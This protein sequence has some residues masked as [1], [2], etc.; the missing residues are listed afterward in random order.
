MCNLP[1]FWLSLNFRFSQQSTI[2]IIKNRA[3][4]VER[5]KQLDFHSSKKRANTMS[6]RF[7]MWAKKKTTESKLNVLMSCCLQLHDCNLRVA[8]ISHRHRRRRLR[9]TDWEQKNKRVMKGFSLSTQ[10]KYYINVRST[11][12]QYKKCFSSYFISLQFDNVE[13]CLEILRQNQVGGLE[14][15]TANDICS[16]R[17]KA[18]LSLFFSLSRYKQASKLKT[19]NKSSQTFVHHPQIHQQPALLL[20]SSQNDMTKER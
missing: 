17:L 6:E 12:C 19:P 14:N 8:N 3:G 20:N 9:P 11:S 15:I 18:V 16:G 1:I 4:Y 5:R 2:K 7:W 13:A 10:F